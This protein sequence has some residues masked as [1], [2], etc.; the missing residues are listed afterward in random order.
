MADVTKALQTT[1]TDRNCWMYQ[2]KTV[3]PLVA[4]VRKWLTQQN[5]TVT[6]NVITIRSST[7]HYRS[8]RRSSDFKRMCSAHLEAD[9]TRCDLG[10][11]WHGAARCRAGAR[12]A[13]RRC[14]GPRGTNGGFDDQGQGLLT[15]GWPWGQCG[16]RP[17]RPIC[18]R[19]AAME[20]GAAIAR[21][22]T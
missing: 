19:S 6:R 12:A 2:K 18:H 3:L 21:E 20:G 17:T 4:C 22:R 7:C 11:I 13:K 8:P 14:Y 9:D 5:T 15:L 10:V 1:I 16:M